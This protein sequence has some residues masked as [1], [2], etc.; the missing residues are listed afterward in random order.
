[1]NVPIASGDRPPS[2]YILVYESACDDFEYSCPR[3]S[4]PN[5][6]TPVELQMRV[7]SFNKERAPAQGHS[8][9]SVFSTD[10]VSTVEDFCKKWS[11]RSD[12]LLT[13]PDPLTQSIASS[14]F[15]FSVLDALSTLF[16]YWRGQIKF[17]IQTKPDPTVV[18]SESTA[19]VVKMDDGNYSGPAPAVPDGERFADG[20]HAVSA[21]LTQV[22]TFTR[23]YMCNSE[24][25]PVIIGTGYSYIGS[26][27]SYQYD[28]D[29]HLYTVGATSS[30]PLAWVAVAAG[31][32]LS[33]AYAMPPPWAEFRWYDASYG[34]L[35]I[36]MSL[37]SEIKSAEL[38]RCNVVRPRSVVSE[39]RKL[40]RQELPKGIRLH[41][42]G[43][44]V[45]PP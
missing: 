7:S 19:L 34:S 18:I 38:K 24:F 29:A 31:D 20:S 23:P 13:G 30:L 17:K 2:L 22:L 10:Q 27:G 28:F 26:A 36:P 45:T 6:S 40:L 8:Y 9:K 37:R 11:V 3:E 35:S 32:D 15:D 14:Y 41:I 1:L 12:Q 43:D 5:S 16:F 44:E 39:T 25:L 4:R 33:F 21:G 42:S